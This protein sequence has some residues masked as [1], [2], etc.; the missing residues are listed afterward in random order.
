[1]ALQDKYKELLDAAASSGVS[2]LQVRE[3]DSVLYIDGEAPTGAVKDQLMGY[4]RIRLTPISGPA[5]WL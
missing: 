4:V 5:M 2:N 1:M 3:Q